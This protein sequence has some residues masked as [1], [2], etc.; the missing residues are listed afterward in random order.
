MTM[1]TAEPIRMSSLIRQVMTS[2]VKKRLL[3]EEALDLQKCKCFQHQNRPLRRDD[4]LLT[5]KSNQNYLLSPLQVLKML[6][7]M[8]K[9]LLNKK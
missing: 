6:S 4:S 7:I 9:E 3:T 8:K 5:C 1:D 2:A